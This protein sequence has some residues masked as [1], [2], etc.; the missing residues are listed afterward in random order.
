MQFPCKCEICSW[1]SSICC[2]IDGILLFVVIMLIGTGW[3]LLKPVLTE[4]ERTIFIGVISMQVLDNIALFI[5]D[6]SAP[7]SVA[8]ERWVCLSRLACLTHLRL[9]QKYVFIVV[10]LLCSAAVLLPILWSIARLK[11]SAG[12]DAGGGDRE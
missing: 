5:V 8:W 2:S 4:Q 3:S 7:G 6:D 12:R 9:F 11:E 10:D 1:Y